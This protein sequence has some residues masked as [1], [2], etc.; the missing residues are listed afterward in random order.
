MK[1]MT[2]GNLSQEQFILKLLTKKVVVSNQLMADFYKIYRLSAHI[3][4]LRKKDVQIATM[5][6]VSTEGNHYAEYLLEE[7]VPAD[8]SYRMYE[9]DDGV[10]TIREVTR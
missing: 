5:D 7:D 4:S 3:L 9:W 1:L 8:R 6:A 2:R 10:C